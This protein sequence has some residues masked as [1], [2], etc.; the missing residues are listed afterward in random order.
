MPEL[1]LACDKNILL[2]IHDW[3]YIFHAYLLDIDRLKCE[4]LFYNFVPKAGFFICIF[5]I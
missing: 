5:L 2:Y 3:L 1:Y 4:F